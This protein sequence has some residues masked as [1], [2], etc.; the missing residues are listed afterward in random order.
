LVL[1]AILSAVLFVSY[2]R[3]KRDWSNPLFL[4]ALSTSVVYFFYAF[5]GAEFTNGINIFGEIFYVASLVLATF[6]YLLAVGSLD[7]NP[8]LSFPID[9]NFLT[10]I[11]WILIAPMI[12]SLAILL[13]RLTDGNLF[14]L[15]D[16][17]GGNAM[18]WLRITERDPLV[19]VS[20]AIFLGL[21]SIMIPAAILNL[22]QKKKKFV[23]VCFFSYFLYLLSTGS[24]SPA[25]ALILMVIIPAI[26]LRRRGRDNLWVRR[27]LRSSAILVAAL[28]ILVTI[29]RDKIEDNGDEMLKA[30]FSAEK[31]G[32]IAD[33][34]L[35][36][37]GIKLPSTIISIYFASTFNN[38]II[39]FDQSDSME[40][41]W[42]YRLFY[43]EY[44]ALD[45][46]V[47]MSNV[48][49]ETILSDNTV[50]LRSIS[51]T[52]DQ[53][54]T[55]LGTLVLEFGV[56]YSMIFSL[57][58]GVLIGWIVRISRKLESNRSVILKSLVFTIAITSSL[59]HPLMSFSIHIQLLILLII[60]FSGSRR[61][62]S[63]NN[64][65]DRINSPA[66]HFIY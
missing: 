49:R 12:L 19:Y 9:N 32:F 62:R 1:I 30:V 64:R 58:Q 39:A 34:T 14:L 60:Y 56:F 27:L 55:N 16:L 61:S 46:I 29:S 18:K 47:P 24:R 66:Q 38:Y 52:G 15:F 50:H 31:L 59:V 23:I 42:G 17:G 13:V 4:Y 6:G 37:Y 54:A 28:F 20:E 36:P 8:S 33:S 21:V 7:R 48:S 26:E 2:Y 5:G 63:S 10:K 25:I 3:N 43:T 41:S 40:K 35:I 11:L 44:K 45:L 22:G 51:P 57:I 53:W 65:P